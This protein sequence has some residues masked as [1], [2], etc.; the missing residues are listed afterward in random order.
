[1]Q[2]IKQYSKV[3][4]SL[5]CL[6]NAQLKQIF[7]DSKSM[8]E[9]IGGKSVL[10][11]IDDI[12]VFVKK[13]PL[14]DLMHMN[15]HGLMHFLRTWKKEDAEAYFQVNQEPRV[16]EFLRGPLTMEQVN[17]FI[18]AV[19]SHGDKHGYT[20]WAACLKETGELI[21][22]IGLNYTDWES[23]F[24]SAVE[25]GCRLGSQY[26]GKSY[27]IEGA[28]A[29]LEYGFKKCSLKEIISFTV[30][31]NVRSIRVMEKNGLKCDL[32]GD[33]GHPLKNAAVTQ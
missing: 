12:P 26:W 5:A 7:A 16:I 20:L 33:F 6:S 2:R 28:K 19:N 10:I 18:P 32:N 25:V 8:H 3:S 23:H 27:A 29:C 14:T 11:F 9:G 4:T 15:T 21:G 1:M 17:D 24:T 30:P 31:S 13:V 22:F